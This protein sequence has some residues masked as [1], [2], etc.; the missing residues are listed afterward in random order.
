MKL[1]IYEGILYFWQLE[2]NG[3]D[4]L[5]ILASD[6]LKTDNSA[7]SYDIVWLQDTTCTFLFIFV[8]AV[9]S[10]KVGLVRSKSIVLWFRMLT[11]ALPA[12]TR[13]P[14]LLWSRYEKKGRT[15]QKSSWRWWNMQKRTFPQRNAWPVE[16]K[17]NEI[18]NNPASESSNTD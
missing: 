12:P 4:I 8:V 3:H 17:G 15:C 9:L 6:S 14:I 2:K 18:L 11:T 5:T 10:L 7:S 16:N 13:P 1:I